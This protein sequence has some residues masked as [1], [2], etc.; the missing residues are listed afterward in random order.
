V[1]VNIDDQTAW[2]TD[3]SGLSEFKDDAFSTT[4]TTS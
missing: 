3:Y 2:D 4:R 1:V